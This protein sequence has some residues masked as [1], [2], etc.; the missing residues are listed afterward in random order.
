MHIYISLAFA[1]VFVCGSV[2]VGGLCH[3]REYL[4]ASAGL[5]MHYADMTSSTDFACIEYVCGSL[6]KRHKNMGLKYFNILVW[7]NGLEQLLL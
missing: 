6:G 1:H 2:F 5:H 3:N 4:S 7:N